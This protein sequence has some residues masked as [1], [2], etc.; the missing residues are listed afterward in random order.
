MRRAGEAR[1][2]VRRRRR[3]GLR[4]RGPQ[5]A[6]GRF[7]RGSRFSAGGETGPL[8]GPGAQRRGEATPRRRARRAPPELRAARGWHRRRRAVAHGAQRE[9]RPSP[10]RPRAPRGLPGTASSGCR[11]RRSALRP[12]RRPA[13]ARGARALRPRLRES[14]G[15][16]GRGGSRHRCRRPR[17]DAR[18]VADARS[19][20]RPQPGAH[21]GLGPGEGGAHRR[22]GR[23]RDAQA[24][25]CLPQRGDGSARSAALGLGA[26]SQRPAGC[27]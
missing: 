21:A 19:G 18:A 15:R 5:K 8:E 20:R 7:L 2:P 27:P 14:A 4:E 22:A 9:L 13:H 23:H 1:P 3:R 6:V 11:L 17:G 12:G 25:G 26:V 24:E 10:C 16:R